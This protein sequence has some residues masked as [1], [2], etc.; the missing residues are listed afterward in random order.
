LIFQS[1][2]SLAIGEKRDKEEA[3]TEVVLNISES[4]FSAK[5]IASLTK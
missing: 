3:F 5:H 4:G 1:L 2:V